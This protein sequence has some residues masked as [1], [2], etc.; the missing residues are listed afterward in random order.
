L[1]KRTKKLIRRLIFITLSGAIIGC[2][3]GFVRGL[4]LGG[5]QGIEFGISKGILIGSSISLFTSVFGLAIYPQALKRFSFTAEIVIKTITYTLIVI[6]LFILVSYLF[7]PVISFKV[8]VEMLV[9]VIIIT[10]GTTLVSTFMMSI[11]RLLGRRILLNF[12]TGKYHHPVEEERIFMFADLVSSTT[13]AEKIGHIEFHKFLNDFFFDITFPVIESNGEI[14]KY[15]GDELIAVWH[16]KDA[17]TNYRCM[18][19]YFE[20]KEEIEKQKNKYVKSYGF[21]P[22]FRVG[23]HCGTVI[24]GEMGDYKREIAFLGDVV[25]TTARIQEESK[26]HK[27]DVLISGKLMSKIN[28]P[29][30]VNTES[31][32]I[33]KLRG[34]E[35]ELELFAVRKI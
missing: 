31:M 22:K 14:Y 13:I 15:V 4:E 17:D 25:N 10:I 26:A 27:Q 24:T 8:Q 29:K 16:V 30:E 20:M 18:N 33:V 9:P 2:I 32:G 34:K 11:D 3:V 28:F 5:L 35:T 12:F 19:C 6:T 23:M 21:T 1:D 7:T